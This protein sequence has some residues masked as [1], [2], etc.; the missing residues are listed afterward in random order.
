VVTLQQMNTK[1]VSLI[2]ALSC[3]LPAL[4]VKLTEFEGGTHGFPALLDAEKSGHQ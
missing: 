1:I 3:S 4:G 2:A